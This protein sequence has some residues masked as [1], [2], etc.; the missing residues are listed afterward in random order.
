MWRVHTAGRQESVSGRSLSLA[1]VAEAGS[2]VC[3]RRFRIQRTVQKVV[4]LI[5]GRVT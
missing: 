2:G 4:K 1:G 5:S 3:E